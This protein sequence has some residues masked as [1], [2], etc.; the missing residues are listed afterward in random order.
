MGFNGARKGNYIAAIGPYIGPCCYE[1][2]EEV[3][4]AIS[5]MEGCEKALIRRS[6]AIKAD[7][8]YANEL[9]LISLGIDKSRISRYEGCTSCE[10]GMFFSHRRDKGRTGRSAA[11]AAS[12]GG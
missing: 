2:G 7:L 1:V 12:L 3:A 4:S 8:G 5:S 11:I 10:E 6:G 9:Q